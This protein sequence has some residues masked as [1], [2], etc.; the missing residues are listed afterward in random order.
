MIRR[1]TRQMHP[2]RPLLG[3]ALQLLLIGRVR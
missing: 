2:Q 1:L 3:P